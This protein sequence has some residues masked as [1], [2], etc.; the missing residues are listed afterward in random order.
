MKKKRTSHDAV[1]SSMQVNSGLSAAFHDLSHIT[2]LRKKQSRSKYLKF[3]ASLAMLLAGVSSLSIT[4]T[5]ARAED[6]TTEQQNNNQQ[7]YAP[8]ADQ[9]LTVSTPLQ[10]GTTPL[11]VLQDGPGTTIFSAQNTYTGST[12]IQQGTLALSG[13]GSIASSSVVSVNKNSKFDVSQTNNDPSIK[14]LAGAGDVVLAGKTLELTNADPSND[15]SGTIS[16]TGGLTVSGGTQ[17]LSG[18]NSYTGDTTVKQNA[19]LNLSGA[20]AGNLTNDGTTNINGGKVSGTA[21]NTGTLTA[22]GGSIGSATNSG[23]MTLKGGNAVSGD[24]TQSAGS[25]TLDGNSIGGTLAANGGQFTVTGN[26]STIGSLTGSANSAQDGL[27]G[28]LTLN[29]ANGQYDGVLSGTGQLLISGGKE[30]LTNQQAYTGYTGVTGGGTLALTGNNAGLSEKTHVNLL[31]GRPD[32]PST[33]D[34]SGA[35]RSITLAGLSW[36]SGGLV[37]LGS[38]T[39]TIQNDGNDNSYSGAISGTGGLNITSG[40]QALSGTNSYTGDTTVSQN[41]G[42]NLSGS[43]AGA[44]INHGTSTITDKATIAGTTTNTGTLTATGG[45]LSSVTNNGTMTAT[46]GTLSSVT[47]NGTMTLGNGSTVSGDVTQQAGTLTLD[48]NTINGT[49]AA[50]N[51]SFNVTSSGSKVGSLTGGL[52]GTLNGTLDLTNAQN[53]TYDGVLSGTGG[54]TVTGGTETLTKAQ[55]Y[56]GNTEVKNGATLALTGDANLSDKTVVNLL[57]GAPILDLSGVTHS[58]TIAGLGYTAPYG[59]GALIKLGNNTLNLQNSSYS[60]YAGSISGTGG[61]NITSGSQKL[62]GNNSYTG[63]TTVSQG[64]TLDLSGGSLASALNNQGTTTIENGGSVTQK[65]TNTNTLNASNST[66]GALDN[67]SGTAT[68]QNTNTGDVTNNATLNTTGGKLNSLNNNAGKSSLTNSDVGDVKNANGATL[69]ATGGSISSA[70]NSSTMTLG[71]GNTVSGNITQNDGTLTL[72]G[73]TIKGTLAANGG[74]FNVTSAG[75]I[76]GSLSGNAAGGLDGTLNLNNA[77]DTYNGVLSGKG[78]LTV[79]GGTETLT[80]AQGYTGDT[81]INQN[82]HLILTGNANLS[83]STYLNFNN[84]TDGNTPALDISNTNNIIAVDRLGG[85]NGAATIN[86]GKQTLSVTN[87]NDTFSGNVSGNGG[88]LSIAGPHEILNGSITGNTNLTTSNGLVE[89]Y[90]GNFSYTGN[91]TVKDGSTVHV[92]TNVLGTNNVTVEKGGRISGVGT[93]GNNDHTSNITIDDGAIISPGLPNHNAS[94]LGIS[95][96]LTV[97]GVSDFA[98]TDINGSGKQANGIILVKGD[99]NLNGTLNTA[100][101]AGQQ[102]SGVQSLYIYAGKYDS[103]DL[104]LII[105]GKTQSNLDNLQTSNHMVALATANNG[106]HLSFWD[107]SNTKSD[108]QVHGGTGTW[109]QGDGS[110]T[111]WTTAS[112]TDNAA[113]HHGDFAIFEQPWHGS[114]SETGYVND[115]TVKGNVEVGGMQFSRTLEGGDVGEPFILKPSDN[116]SSITLNGNDHYDSAESFLSVTNKN[117]DEQSTG[118]IFN[119]TNKISTIRVGNGTGWGVGTFAIISTNIKDD[120]NNPTTL[121]KTDLGKLLLSGDNNYNGG[122]VINSGTLEIVSDK[123]LGASGTALNIDGGTLQIGKD[124]TSNRSIILG[125]NTNYTDTNND[126]NIDLFGNTWTLN[127]SIIGP[128]QLVVSSSQKSY[129]DENPN[130]LI[131]DLIQKQTKAMNSVGAGVGTTSVLNLNKDNTYTGNTVIKGISGNPTTGTDSFIVNANS[132]TPFGNSS[133][134]AHGGRIVLDKGATVNM[135]G[136][137]NNDPNA[138]ATLGYHQTDIYNFSVLNFNNN[139]SADHAAITNNDNSVINFN[140][141]SSAGSAT[142]KN[143]NPDDPKPA[144]INFNGKSTAGQ[145]S[146]E[147]TTRG[148]ITFNDSSS[149]GTSSTTNAGSILFT[150]NSD[151]KDATITNKD[152]SKVDISGL[153]ADG[154]NIGSLSG[155]G[156]V[157]LGS[158]Q[159]TLGALNKDDTLSASIKDG[160]QAN[161]QGGSLTKTGTG[162]LTLTGNNSNTGATNISNGV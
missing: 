94:T 137:T 129:T 98:G 90:D 118:N 50:N 135:N 8:A 103:H 79:S 120:P 23:T 17:A 147:N 112:G 151:A 36:G 72:D 67:N 57:N 134:E 161:G 85:G 122:T 124:T 152:G 111:N 149:A 59:S 89:L 157:D 109:Q 48:G 64:A 143:A 88:T 27:Q 105:D 141:T 148:V 3:S 139:S 84:N 30:T 43:L 71:S 69:T 65:T 114:A 97:N 102:G 95:G 145:A 87:A 54:L 160:G 38:N 12:D 119:K 45:T 140:G 16:G 108:G 99:L 21:T 116:N 155:S 73:N 52:D 77:K 4:S 131:Q 32:S 130:P 86:L 9:T 68:L 20:V 106:D 7:T 10:D 93:I 81:N 53:T 100:S 19:G 158:K 75:S 60:D 40:S 14:A 162:T 125:K 91:T 76:V 104:S 138:G 51:G 78:G 26:G 150:G 42:L 107:G 22:T 156:E 24:V 13:A 70:T 29:H 31:D 121:V 35:T 132:T 34:I 133:S 41:A 1:L 83:P 46:G 11:S 58:I 113:W 55:T 18:A 127:G 110:S 115:I 28:I 142:I 33:L 25:L 62:T 56:T 136:S 44:L 117:T 153:Q 2:E 126:Q 6:T 96:N 49:L 63:D 159:L 47:N 144:T 101:L 123:S 146:I 37:K 74:S 39:L 92:N 15:Y 128:G 66:L 154:I 61:L 5:S 80:Q 82:G